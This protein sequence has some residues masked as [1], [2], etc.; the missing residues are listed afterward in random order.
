MCPIPLLSLDDATRIEK[1]LDA[2][3]AD[4]ELGVHPNEALEKVATAYNLT[5]EFIRLVGRAYNSGLTN[6]YIHGEKNTRKLASFPVCDPETIVRKLYKVQPKQKSGSVSLDY[7]ATPV[8][9]GLKF[10]RVPR[11]DYVKAADFRSESSYAK[12]FMTLYNRVR[13]ERDEYLSAMHKWASQADMCL[14]HLAD[15][16]RSVGAVDPDEVLE[17][18]RVYIRGADVLFKTAGVTKAKNVQ[19]SRNV[20]VDWSKQ[21]YASVK[22]AV[23]AV[24]RFAEASRRYQQIASRIRELEA[25][26]PLRKGASAAQERMLDG[27][28]AT[29]LLKRVFKEA[30]GAGHGR[31]QGRRQGSRGRDRSDDDRKESVKTRTPPIVSET[32][33]AAGQA[34][35][36]LRELAY[37]TLAAPATKSVVEPSY[38]SML[39]ALHRE[40][41]T[42]QVKI[43]LTHLMLDDPIIQNYDP[44]EVLNAFQNI[45]RL[46]PHITVYPELLRG[47]LRKL[48]AAGTLEPAD[49]AALLDFERK[50]G[51]RARSPDEFYSAKAVQR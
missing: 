50:L 39:T 20:P 44:D 17:N 46:A 6:Y 47:T 3:Y 48:L 15:Y 29:A 31:G 24:E 43:Y 45:A 37:R 4:V 40:G 16:F 51:A 2:M 7:Y 11:D 30:Q 41:N 36:T 26:L 1:V 49:F 38:E 25:R 5:P 13:K 9:L 22:A 34:G 42:A 8:E 21:P 14:Q 19:Y 33:Q 35:R 23:F 18:C 10:P 28:I 32:S 12:E 27:P